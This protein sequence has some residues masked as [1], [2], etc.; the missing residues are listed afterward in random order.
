[1]LAFVFPPL[2]LLIGW[3]NDIPFQSSMSDY[4]FAFAPP[5]SELRVFPGRVVFAGILFVLGFFLILYRGSL[6][7]KI[8]R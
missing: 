6:G 8:G 1:L 7:P 4:Y 3:W 5:T 2:L